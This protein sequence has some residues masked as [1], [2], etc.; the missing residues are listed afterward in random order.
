[1]VIII[2]A[3]K[4]VRFMQCL[5]GFCVIISGIVMCVEIHII[6]VIM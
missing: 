4:P 1:M 6:D 3:F 5:S 2:G